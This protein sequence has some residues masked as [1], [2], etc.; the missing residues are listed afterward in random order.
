MDMI[1]KYLMR[2]YEAEDVVQL[3]ADLRQLYL[4]RNIK[5]REYVNAIKT[6]NKQDKSRNVLRKKARLDSKWSRWL[7]KQG[8]EIKNVRK[9]IMADRYR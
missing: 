6:L 5:K 9:A 4:Q 7:S 2:I 8:R 3:K 1:G